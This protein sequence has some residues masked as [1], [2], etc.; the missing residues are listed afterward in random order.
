MKIFLTRW[1]QRWARREGLADAALCN[2]V[3]EL[4]Q[5]FVEANL[6]GGL[7]KKRVALPGRGKSG[8]TRTL[9]AF[10][11]ADAAFFIYGFAKNQRDNITPREL[12]ALK[13]LAS[14]LLRY[15]DAQ[16]QQATT[17]GILKEIS[18]DESFNA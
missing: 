8:G 2:V 3:E 1:F 9:I 15:D 12:A 11:R 4:N 10:R 7:Y 16:R 13:A 17:G 6:G 18:D 5:G 14:E